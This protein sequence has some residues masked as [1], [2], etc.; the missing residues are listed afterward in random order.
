MF[1][2]ILFVPFMVN[3]KELKLEWQKS[4]GGIYDESGVSGG[5]TSDGGY[6]V[7]STSYI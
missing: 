4:W 7:S 2:I 1:L 3:G 6:V 5:A